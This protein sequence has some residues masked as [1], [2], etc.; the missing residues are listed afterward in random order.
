MELVAVL[1]V[2]QRLARSSDD[3][4]RRGE[5]PLEREVVKRGNELALR[6]IARAAEDD[7]R[8]WLGDA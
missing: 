7:D 3:G 2:A 8:R 6:E 5:Q 4:E 1:L